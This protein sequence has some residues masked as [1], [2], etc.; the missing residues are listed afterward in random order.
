[1]VRL[2]LDEKIFLLVYECAESAG[3]VQIPLVFRRTF[4][5]V[6]RKHTV[7][8]SN[9]AK[10]RNERQ[11]T[12]VYKSRQNNGKKPCGDGKS[13]EGIHAVSAVHKTNKFFLQNIRLPD[14]MSKNRFILISYHTLREGKVNKPVIKKI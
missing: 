7:I 3:L 5:D 12:P 4:L 13:A 8:C 1:M 2:S 11:N 10:P 14:R 9:D 6:L